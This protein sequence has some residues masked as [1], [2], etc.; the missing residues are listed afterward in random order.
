MS[1]QSAKKRLYEL[2]N[3]EYLVY[4]KIFHEK[5]GI[6]RVSPKGIAVTN[7]DLPPIKIRLGSYEHDSQLVDLAIILEQKTG[8]VWRTD[9]QIRHDLGLKGVGVKGHSPDGILEFSSGERT[10][11]ELEL[12]S[13]GNRRIEKILKE[14]AVSQYGTV[15]YFVNNHALAGK[16]LSARIPL[17]RVFSWPEMK[18]LK[19]NEK[20][21]S[22]PVTSHET[23]PEQKTMDFFRRK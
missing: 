22:M 9:R 16:I 1:I 8:A 11:V 4:E 10:A 23:N 14:Y 20:T 2:K 19:V 5:P 3:V 15:W 18:E 17:I 6:Y 12:S 7:D 21:V 13:K